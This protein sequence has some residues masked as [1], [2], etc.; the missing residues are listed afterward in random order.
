[1]TA[2]FILF[3]A[4]NVNEDRNSICHLIL[5]PVIDGKTQQPQHFYMN[6]AAPFYMV[7]SGISAEKVESFAPVSKVWPQIQAIIDEY[8]IAV[9]SADGYSALSLFGTLSR[10]KV[11]FNPIRYCNAKSILRRS[12]KEVS[13]SLDYLSAKY[14]GNFLTAGMPTKI[15]ERWVELVVKS[16]EDK[17]VSSLDD[18]LIDV[19]IKIGTISKDEFTPSKCKRD[20]VVRNANLLDTS[21]I[22]VDAQP[23]NPLF[24]LNV[25]FTGK[26]ESM[27]RDEARAAVIRIGGNAPERLT[28]ETDLLV[29][30]VQDLRVVGE[31]GLSGKMKTAEKY[32]AAG[33]PIE[34]IDEADFIEMLNA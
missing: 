13:Y 4:E 7:S 33:C 34:I 22:E 15:A 19:K 8:P 28:Q 20:Y 6:P 16:L 14:Y 9:C 5:V 2:S 24:G 23:N 12:M 31:K 18:F 1:M 17:N 30:G 21:S 3:H 25:V 26:M 32:R 27:K 29:V 11:P 10:L